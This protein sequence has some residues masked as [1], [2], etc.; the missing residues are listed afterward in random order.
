M[1]LRL[2]RVLT[3]PLAQSFDE[4]REFPDACT[5]LV[6][7]LARPL[8]GALLG[9]IGRHEPL[10]MLQSDKLSVQNVLEEPCL[11]R[12]GSCDRTRRGWADPTTVVA[13]CQ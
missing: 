7:F 4:L 13:V 2:L 12:L 10:A 8:V 6:G 5:R 3:E 11:G 9:S 1:S